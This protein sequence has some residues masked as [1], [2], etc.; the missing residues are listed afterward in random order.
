MKI[1]RN[2][3]VGLKE[4]MGRY[5]SE[6]K[7]FYYNVFV[8]E[9]DYKI[10]ITRRSYVLFKI[11][12]NIFES[13]PEEIEGVSFEKKGVFI[14]TH[15]VDLLKKYDSI[16]ENKKI[17]IVDD[18]II[19][20]R[21]V[22]AVLKKFLSLNYNKLKIW[23]INCNVDAK[24]LDNFNNSSIKEY[25]GHVRYVM[26]NEW[27]K[28]SDCL[29]NFIISSNFGYVSYVNS[30]G[31]D[32]SLSK[33]EELIMK[34]YKKED[35]CVY[36]NNNSYFEKFGITSKI[37]FFKNNLNI[38]SC[39]R[40]YEKSGKL[41]IIPYIFIGSVKNKSIFDYCNLLLDNFDCKNTSSWLQL[42][43]D[44]LLYKR[45]VYEISEKLMEKFS[46]SFSEFKYYKKFDCYYESYDLERLISNNLTSKSKED[47]SD[48]QEKISEL[49]KCRNILKE[50]CCNE[51][52]IEGILTGYL[53]SMHKEDELRAD[54]NE[55]RYIGITISDI[56]EIFLKE[57]SYRDNLEVLSNIINL[58]DCGKAALVVSKN[59]K[60][61]EIVIDEYIRHGEQIYKS[62]CEKYSDV[63]NVFYEFYNQ[64]R[65]VRFLQ[66]LD[67]A[68]Y[69]DKKYNTKNFSEFVCN[70]NEDEFSLM[71]RTI[72]LDML[73]GRGIISNPYNEVKY[74]CEKYYNY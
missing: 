36:D 6:V 27:P 47:F 9:Y 50:N 62:I 46:K 15:S 43:S 59:K 63:Y 2:Q 19:N 40:F 17:L 28:L 13:I 29:T 54:K 1:S 69:F 57:T 42:Y 67:F 23:C 68:N 48:T 34:A 55:E 65:E 3:L 49:I 8:S 32:S 30:Y 24:C 4:I 45:T 53:R 72:S 73:N 20:G 37:Y 39:M 74:Y 66:L 44:E 26:P 38:K 12:E 52:E 21:T 33:I 70:F 16:L 5:Y 18:I 56:E 64:K 51:K 25:F 58:W 10:L 7:E 35:V 22:R 61:K 71:L 41:T 31:I 11:F 60:D 14:N